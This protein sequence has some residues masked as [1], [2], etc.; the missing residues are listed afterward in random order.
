VLLTE[1]ERI[2]FKL[3]KETVYVDDK[4]SQ[5]EYKALVGLKFD[6]IALKC[7]DSLSKLNLPFRFRYE[8][9]RTFGS[10]FEKYGDVIK[11]LAYP[12]NQ[13]LAPNQTVMDRRDKMPERHS[14]RSMERRMSTSRSRDMKRDY[15]PDRISP[16]RNKYSRSSSRHSRGRSYDM[17]ES[18]RPDH[19]RQY[20]R[21]HDS[22][23][24]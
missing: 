21:T 17:K 13:L 3:T 4:D 7:Y 20:D 14:R 10:Y 1:L 5:D 24:K 18:S 2:G 8:L 9:S 23:G 11:K 12:A 6:H 16:Y 19:R 15:Y 22:R